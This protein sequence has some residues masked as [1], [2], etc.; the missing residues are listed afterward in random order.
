MKVSL[1]LRSARAHH[2]EASLRSFRPLITLSACT[3]NSRDTKLAHSGG[4][5]RLPHKRTP[6]AITIVVREGA[7]N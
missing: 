1:F 6:L 4:T 3:D 2:L 7:G 5:A